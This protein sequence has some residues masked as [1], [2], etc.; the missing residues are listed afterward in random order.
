M[1]LVRGRQRH[2]CAVVAVLALTGS[3]FV[4]TEPSGAAPSPIDR[5]NSQISSLQA[6]AEALAQ[7]ITTDQNKVSVAAEAYDMDT[8]LLQQDQLKLTKTDRKSTRLN[9]SH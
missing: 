8:V 6:R 2:I 1:L 9:S 5:T 7:K 4:V 3:L